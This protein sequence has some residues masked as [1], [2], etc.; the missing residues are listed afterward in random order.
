LAIDPSATGVLV[1]ASWATRVGNVTISL[2]G[3]T[4][5]SALTL[6]DGS[7]G[8]SN[9]PAG[10]TYTLNPSKA[11]DTAPANGV[12]VADLALIQAVILGKRTS[13]PAGLWRFV[14]ADHEF[15][16]PLNPWSAPCQCCYTNRM[17]DVTNGDFIAIK[18]GDVNGSWKAPAGRPNSVLEGPGQGV[19]GAAAVPEVWF[20]VGQQNAEL[21][22]T[23][24][25]EL[26]VSGFH[27]V[28]SAQFSLAWDS[29][30]LRCVGTGSYGLR[31]LSAGCFGTTLAE[32]GK[33]AFAWYDPEAAGVTL[34]DGTVL[35][36]VSFDVIGKTG[37]VSAVVLAGTPTAQE[38]SVDLALPTF[39]ARDW[40]VAV[41]GPGVVV[42]KPDYTNGV[43]RLSVPTEKGRSYTLEFTDSLIPAKWRALPAVAGDGTVTVLADPA[44]TNQQR[45]YQ[46][47]VQ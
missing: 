3:D 25:V 46:V 15:P 19:V 8:L 16:N 1:H 9:L 12:T 40:S 34:A 36:T 43:F 23:V 39:G 32:S 22:Q 26:A 5:L 20:G 7:Y 35:F 31:G 28:T 30:P 18:L 42:N 47:R 27:Q 14:P 4:N 17:I 33:L 24:T 29:A 21:G 38:V 11:D 6:A 10:G 13:S 37:S 44:V 45:F 41:V 2:T